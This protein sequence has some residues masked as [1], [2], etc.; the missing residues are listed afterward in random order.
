M[1]FLKL[2][3]LRDFDLEEELGALTSENMRKKLVEYQ[4]AYKYLKA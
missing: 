4:E 2:K 1:A 3:T